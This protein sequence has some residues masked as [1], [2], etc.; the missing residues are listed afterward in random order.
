[1][2]YSCFPKWPD[3]IAYVTVTKKW[4]LD[5]MLCRILGDKRANGSMERQQNGQ[6]TVF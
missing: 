2:F 6:E 3:N 5:C 4:S 1:M